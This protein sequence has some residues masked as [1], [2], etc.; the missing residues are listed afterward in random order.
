MIHFLYGDLTVPLVP[1]KEI[2]SHAPMI[3]IMA[4]HGMHGLFGDAAFRSYSQRLVMRSLGMC[5]DGYA[6]E[7]GC[8]WSSHSG[9]KC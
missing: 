2:A 8:R 7:G 4:R 5:S 3:R 6:T 1:R 9:G